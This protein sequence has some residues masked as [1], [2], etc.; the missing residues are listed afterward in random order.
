MK[1]HYKKN[2]EGRVFC[3]GMVDVDVTF[4]G[5]WMKKGHKSHIG[6]A[7]VVEVDLGLA[8]DFVVMSNWCSMC[9]MEKKVFPQH[10]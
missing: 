1:E 5:S 9:A 6:V 8:L 10:L 2:Y 4:D 7:F 3:D